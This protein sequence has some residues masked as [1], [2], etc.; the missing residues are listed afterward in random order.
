[1][2]SQCN[3]FINLHVVE[4]ISRQQEITVI[5]KELWVKFKVHKFIL[6]N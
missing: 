3:S 6:P 2:S 4:V 1:M 5:S